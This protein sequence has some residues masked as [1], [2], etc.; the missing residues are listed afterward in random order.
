MSKPQNVQGGVTK[1][2]T[3]TRAMT[4][5]TQSGSKLL[6]RAEA[7]KMLDV[8]VST[9]RRMDERL[10]PFVDEQGV[11]LYDPRRIEAVRA[12]IKQTVTTK[13]HDPYGIDGE[14]AAS[15][16]EIFEQG[17]GAVDAVR[18]LRAHPDA[19]ERLFKQWARMKNALVLDGNNLDQIM[20]EA[21]VTLKLDPALRLTTADEIALWFMRL[22][23]GF[24]SPRPRRCVDGVE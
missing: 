1:T 22:A 24:Q 12:T 21:I 23:D 20:H 5:P 7:A 13:M 4:G 11:H 6:R 15:A 17:R 19:I 8:S 10:E 14:M 3:T 9:L 2:I 18:E 16:F